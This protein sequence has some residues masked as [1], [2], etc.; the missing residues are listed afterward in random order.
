MRGKGEVLLTS[1]SQGPETLFYSPTV[2]RTVPT[3]K[4]GPPPDVNMSD[5]GKPRTEITS[6][7][8]FSSRRYLGWICVAS[9]REGQ[10]SAS[11]PGAW[12]PSTP[13]HQ[14]PLFLCQ[15]TASRGHRV[16]HSGHRACAAHGPSVGDQSPL[17]SWRPV[18]W[19]S[20]W[21]GRSS[22]QRRT[23][24]CFPWRP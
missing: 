3:A 1:R 18:P 5:A 6:K 13:G 21:R 4:K 7:F 22:I 17:C 11:P 8:P 19:L 12:I 10:S 24:S 2:H 9:C 16:L 15:L 23:R 14:S 20:T